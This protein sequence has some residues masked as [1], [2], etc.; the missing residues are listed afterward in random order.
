[1]C[2][3]RSSLPKRHFMQ[4]AIE[5]MKKCSEEGPMVGAIIEKDGKIVSE[6]Y[7][8]LGQQGQKGLHA[9]RMAIEAAQ[10]RGIDLNGSAIYSTLEPCVD[11]GSSTTCCAE[12]IVQAG[13]THVYI[14]RYDINPNIY[15]KGWK[16]L[17]DS[18]LEP[19]DFDSDLR[20]DIDKLNS[21][22]VGNFSKGEGPSGGAKFDYTLN[23]GKYPIAI[24]ETD[25]RTV[26]TRW[27]RCGV[28]SI[29]A[30]AYYGERV[31]LVKY[32]TDFSQIDD[33]KSYSFCNNVKVSEGEIVAF[34]SDIGCVLVKVEKVESGP[35]YGSLDT[36]VKIKYQV[37]K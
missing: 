25:A 21:K 23:D 9:E 12:L 22:F 13:C 8:K 30:N 34:V 5:Q 16:K 7:R 14:G 6:G 1:M 32:A 3:K 29:Y 36:I 24:S 35:E 10:A 11:T 4:K 20:E 28:R 37:R 17:I 18:G 27:S 19:Y 26:M 33:P 15:R 31:A 2:D